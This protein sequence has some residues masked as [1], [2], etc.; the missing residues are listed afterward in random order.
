MPDAGFFAAAFAVD[1]VT[2]E[3]TEVGEWEFPGNVGAATSTFL[4]PFS[5][6]SRVSEN[7]RS[8]IRFIYFLIVQVG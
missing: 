2:G 3:E 6:I 5:R 8:C 4:G 1:P 7:V